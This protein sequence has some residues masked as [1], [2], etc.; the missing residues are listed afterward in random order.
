MRAVGELSKK[1]FQGVR[2]GRPRKL[3][4]DKGLESAA[5]HA[6]RHPLREARQVI[7]KILDAVAALDELPV[8]QF[9]GLGDPFRRQAGDGVE[10]RPFLFRPHSLVGLSRLLGRALLR[11]CGGLGRRPAA[12][13]LHFCGCVFERLDQPLRVGLESLLREPDRISPR[14]RLERLRQRLGARHF[15]L[16]HQNRND[17]LAES[18][19]R[20]D[21]DADKIL[22][23][24]ETRPACFICHSEPIGTYQHE[25][26]VTCADLLL[27]HPNKVQPRPDAA[28]DI[29][30]QALGGK[31]LFETAKGARANP[32]ASSRR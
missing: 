14:E 31:G 25:H 6:Q 19:R 28:L 32:A 9:F 12:R 27:D 5:R 29:H 17:P 1:A 21:L 16:L 2:I 24:F 26:R 11:R 18:E 4:P 23:I 3:R 30:K 10:P 15:G 20:F 7:A 13:L 22:R 8:G